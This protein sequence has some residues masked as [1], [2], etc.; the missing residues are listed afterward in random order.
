MPKPDTEATLAELETEFKSLAG[1]VDTASARRRELDAMIV[2]RK[3]EA[4]A[5][6]K[7]RGM[8]AME[9]EALKSVLN[10]P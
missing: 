5:R 7:I 2:R 4:S 9:K 3:R 8:D 10:E 1:V 6:V